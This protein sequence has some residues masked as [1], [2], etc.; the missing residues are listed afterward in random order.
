MRQ[1]STKVTTLMWLSMMMM[2]MRSRDTAPYFLRPRARLAPHSQVG[3]TFESLALDRFPQVN[4]K[5]CCL[6][7]QVLEPEAPGGVTQV[8]SLLWPVQPGSIIC[9]CSS[10]LAVHSLRYPHPPTDT[11]IRPGNCQQTGFSSVTSTLLSKIKPNHT[12]LNSR[13][14]V[15]IGAFNVRTFCQIGQQASLAETLLS[16]K[17]VVCFVS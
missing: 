6:A 15:F 3:Q 11:M 9:P 2:M 16:L 12:L 10:S 13:D 17:I 4:P 5:T 7:G 14:P 8:N 1:Q